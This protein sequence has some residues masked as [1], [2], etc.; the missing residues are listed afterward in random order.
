MAV[1]HLQ[2][3]AIGVIVAAAIAF[4]GNTDVTR[5]IMQTFTGAAATHTHTYVRT[6]MY[7]VRTHK[8][9]QSLARMISRCTTAPQHVLRRL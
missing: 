4:I 1:P 8:H 3:F 2:L 5:G 9:T 6:R 7:D